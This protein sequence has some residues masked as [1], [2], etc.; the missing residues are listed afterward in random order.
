MP[1]KLA[2]DSGT[3]VKDIVCKSNSYCTIST[4]VIQKDFLYS[5]GQQFCHCDLSQMFEHNHYFFP[6]QWVLK[7]GVVFVAFIQEFSLPFSPML[8]RLVK[9]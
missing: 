2:R 1:S 6:L 8:V 7:M 5:L 3:A 4:V 9:S